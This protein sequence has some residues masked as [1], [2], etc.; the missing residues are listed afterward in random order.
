VAGREGNRVASGGALLLSIR[1]GGEGR[2][3]GWVGSVALF[4]GEEGT[5]G[6]HVL[7]AVAATTFGWLCPREEGSWVGPTW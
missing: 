4:L 6:W 2:Q 1:F 7:E 5:P 3:R